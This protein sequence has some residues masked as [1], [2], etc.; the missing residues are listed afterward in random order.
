MRGQARMGDFAALSIAQLQKPARQQ[1]P[2][3]T[4][5]VE[6]TVPFDDATSILGSIFPTDRFRAMRIPFESLLSQRRDE[7]GVGG[8]VASY[9][10]TDSLPV[11]GSLTC[12]FLVVGVGRQGCGI[13]C[14]AWITVN[15][16]DM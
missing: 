13:R 8:R 9:P 5:R 10:V 11:L 4:K 12:P 6:S 7:D 14:G 15:L 3:V 1:V 16:F 2:D